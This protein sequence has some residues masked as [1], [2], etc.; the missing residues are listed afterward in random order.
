MGEAVAQAWGVALDDVA[1]W[2][3]HGHT[4]ARQDGRIGFSSVRGGD[5]VGDH[6]VYFCGIGERIE[7]THRSSSRA[8]YAQG[9]LRAAR[10]LA[11]KKFGLFDMQDVLA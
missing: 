5:I 11:R 3:R 2:A 7:I 9:S 1:T 6:T 4:G 8:T 10:Y